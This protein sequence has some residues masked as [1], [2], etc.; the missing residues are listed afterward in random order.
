LN[1][2]TRSLATAIDSRGR[3]I[4]T[5][6]DEYQSKENGKRTLRAM[7]ENARQGFWNG[8]LPP[9]GC[10]IVAAR[11]R[12]RNED[13]TYRRDHLRALAQRVEVVDRSEVRVMGSKAELLRTLAAAA[14][15]E[16][17]AIGVRSLVP[18]WRARKDK[19]RTPYWIRSLAGIPSLNGPGSRE[20]VPS[21]H[22]EQRRRKTRPENN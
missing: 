20:P 11:H 4:M 6:F 16:S 15:V 14:N 19:V 18:K 3:Q 1:A 2:G 9:I 21:H 22:S 13:G 12:L 7:K 8:A 10:R 17:A 5:L